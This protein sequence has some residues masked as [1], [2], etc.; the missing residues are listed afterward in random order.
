MALFHSSVCFFSSISL[1]DSFR[2]PLRTSK[3]FIKCILKLLSYDLA[4]SQSLAVRLILAHTIGRTDCRL[5]FVWLGLCS[6]PSTGILLDHRRWLGEVIYIELLGV[7]DGV[8]LIDSWEFFPCTWFLTDPEMPPFFSWLF[9]TLFSMLPLPEFS[10]SLCQ[11]SPVYPTNIFYF[12]FHAVK[13]IFWHWECS[14]GFKHSW[15]CN[16]I[17][18]HYTFFYLDQ[19]LKHKVAFDNGHTFIPIKLQHPQKTAKLL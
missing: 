9:Q 1:I 17:I 14:F 10:C 6:D 4:K 13:H 12:L 19:K 2:T 3:I 5:K 11:P 15:K 16:I 7:S 8:I 18:L